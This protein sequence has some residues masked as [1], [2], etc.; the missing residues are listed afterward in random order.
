M[1]HI[2]KEIVG[3]CSGLDILKCCA[4]CCD[5]EEKTFEEDENDCHFSYDKESDIF[6]A[7]LTHPNTGCKRDI[8]GIAQEFNNM[9]IGLEI[10]DYRSE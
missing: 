1:G 9:I 5:L 10:V 7:V 4:K 2:Y 8:F 3:N 6:H